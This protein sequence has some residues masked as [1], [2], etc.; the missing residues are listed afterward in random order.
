[1]RA[2]T[3]SIRSLPCATSGR[4]ERG[5]TL[6][7]LIFTVVILAVLLGLA[8]PAMRD[9]V[10]DQRVKTAAGDVHAA[11]MYARSEAIKRNQ[12]VALCAK[13]D[14]SDGC[15]NSTDWARGWI[16]Y[17]DGDG[18]GFPTLAGDILR[19][20]DALSDITVTGTGSN[21]TYQGN[22]RLRASPTTFVLSTDNSAI[23]MRCVRLD[24]S[25]RP[26]IQVDTDKNT[27]GCQ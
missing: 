19:K 3:N 1:M 12:F 20:Q 13:N 17:L 15:Q 8:A 14:T 7:E 26:N 18:N 4:G 21:V 25:G 11:L 10:L 27:A 16:V 23:T 5:F 22:G 9:L 24:V 2:L 6:I